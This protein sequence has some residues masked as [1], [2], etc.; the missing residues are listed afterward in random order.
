MK[1]LSLMKLS[2]TAAVVLGIAG[3]TASAQQSGMMHQ[4]MVDLSNLS[5]DRQVASLHYCDSVYRVTTGKGE[6]L[7]FQEFDL[8]FK[9]DASDMG[10][11]RG[12]PAL[13]GASMMGDRAF[14]IFAD[15]S[16]ISST[17]AAGC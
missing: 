14:V 12:T 6:T 8:R 10:P 11:P 16:E 15:P 13:I 9:T 3:M 2:A 17:I 5:P 4:E 1:T 7:Q